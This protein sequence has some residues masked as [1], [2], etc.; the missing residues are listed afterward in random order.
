M[1]CLIEGTASTPNL[2]PKAAAHQRDGAAL[3]LPHGQLRRGQWPQCQT[4]AEGGRGHGG[5]VAARLGWLGV[6]V[7]VVGVRDGDGR[8][9]IILP[10]SVSGMRMSW[11]SGG[12]MGQGEAFGGSLSNSP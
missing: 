12:K 2:L 8:T 9:G 11:E 5:Q 6:W 1:V 4:A 10:G 7:A 3:L